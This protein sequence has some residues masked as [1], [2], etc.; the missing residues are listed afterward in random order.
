MAIL[1]FRQLATAPQRCDVVIVG[2]GPAGISVARQFEGSG[3]CVVL[4]ETG[5]EAHDDAAE[6]CSEFESVGDRRAPAQAVRRRIFGGTSLVWT[7]RCVPLSPIDF[8][9]RSWVPGSGW[10]IDET[11]LAPY[12]GAAGRLLGIGPHAEGDRL[13]GVL[14]KQ[15]DRPAWDRRVFAAEIYQCS[16][17]SDGRGRIVPPADQGQADQLGALSHGTVPIAVDFAEAARELFAASAHLHDWQ[18]AHVREVLSDADG[19]RA[20]G[21][22][23]A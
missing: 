4:L 18:H 11:E 12:W 3:C 13:W 16:V 7:G 15:P 6:S 17:R 14:D 19:R 22:A 10:P 23:I 20:I 8:Q 2:T 9:A 21:V 1:D 5:G